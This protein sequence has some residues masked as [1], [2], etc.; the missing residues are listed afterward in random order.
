VLDAQKLYFQIGAPSFPAQIPAKLMSIP[1][2]GG[3]PAVVYDG[4][5]LANGV[6]QLAQ[7][8]SNLFIGVSWLMFLPKVPA[9][10]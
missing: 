6:E 3:P 4:S 8:Q 10:L 2:A 7:D 1:K 9:V 5:Y